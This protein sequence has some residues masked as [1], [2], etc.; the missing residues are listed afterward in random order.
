MSKTSRAALR[1]AQAGLGV[2]RAR[3]LP[4]LGEWTEPGVRV[5]LAQA[6]ANLNV[7]DGLLPDAPEWQTEKGAAIR[8][9]LEANVAALEHALTLFGG[10][11]WLLMTSTM[12]R[13]YGAGLDAQKKEVFKCGR[14]LREERDRQEAAE[15]GKEA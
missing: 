15:A 13:T 14:I 7:F 1:V 5:L 3:A 2:L 8:E 4:H 12:R 6:R 9:E 11:R 10:G